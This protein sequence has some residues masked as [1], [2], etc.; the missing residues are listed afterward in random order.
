MPNIAEKEPIME[1]T[2]ALCE[3]LVAEAE[4]AD[5]GRNIET[6]MADMDARTHYQEVRRMQDELM[7]R[8]SRGEEVPSEEV[9]RYEKERGALL[10]KEVVRD[11][12]EAQRE[13]QAVQDKV[14]QYVTKTFELGR[15]PAEADFMSC[16][17]GGCAGCSGC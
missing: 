13:M 15:V 10:D 9:A 4:F 7:R 6:F 2:R 16:G 17:A 1:K 12:V 14:L 5:I 3:A 8:R 11:F